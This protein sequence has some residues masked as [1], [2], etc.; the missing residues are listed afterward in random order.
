MLGVIYTKARGSKSVAGGRGRRKRQYLRHFYRAI[1]SRICPITFW[2]SLGDT[3]ARPRARRLNEV[4]SGSRRVN[5]GDESPTSGRAALWQGTISSFARPTLTLI[6]RLAKS[7]PLAPH[8]PGPW[9]FA[10][11][12]HKEGYCAVN[13]LRTKT[14]QTA[15]AAAVTA[16]AMTARQ[17]MHARPR[18]KRRRRASVPSTAWACRRHRRI[19]APRPSVP[20]RHLA[21]PR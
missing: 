8:I 10:G 21:R 2:G 4:A 13:R 16:A 1:N 11:T 9:R 7:A 3:A 12:A 15:A 6:S 18:A 19:G 20:A 17:K 14:V 5:V